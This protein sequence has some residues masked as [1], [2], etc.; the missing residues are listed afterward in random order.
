MK[1]FASVSM[2]V[3]VVLFISRLVS[4]GFAPDPADGALAVPIDKTLG[5]A[6]YSASDGDVYFGNSSTNLTLLASGI[7]GSYDSDLDIYLYSYDLGVS[8]E[9][10]TQ[11][12]WS[13]G[14]DVWTFTT[15]YTMPMITSD[16][17]DISVDAGQTAQFSAS[18]ETG[19]A[20][21]VAWYHD[22][23]LITSSDYGPGSCTATLT[24]DG[25]TTLDAGQ[26]Y[27]TVTNL[28]EMPAYSNTAELTVTPEP[29]TL[30]LLAVGSFLVK[31]KK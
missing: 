1:R 6:S 14:G 16:P 19:T 7:S 8:L 11:Y 9:Y 20:A 10:D 2:C 24:L 4:A 18:F 22:D 31:R 26:Y 3:F 12:Y 25:V 13:A 17:T 23:Q 29:A 21:N 28:S 27:C 15:L 5:W 30:C